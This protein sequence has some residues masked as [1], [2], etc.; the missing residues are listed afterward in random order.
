MMK[1]IIGYYLVILLSGCGADTPI[2][3]SKIV[4]TWKTSLVSEKGKTAG[5][6]FYV[7][8]KPNNN[9]GRSCQVI[10]DKKGLYA[11]CTQY[12]ITGSTKSGRIVYIEENAPVGWVK[13]LF[14]TVDDN[15]NQ[16]LI[17]DNA[18]FKV[19]SETELLRVRN[20]LSKARNW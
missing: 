15:N 8:E 11:V 3:H 5:D 17:R 13:V 6:A 14:K 7:F 4:G 18:F 9:M 10:P 20:A 1:K 19:Y 12:K 2:D 16:A